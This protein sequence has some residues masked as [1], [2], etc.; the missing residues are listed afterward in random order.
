MTRL[1]HERTNL[2]KKALPQHTGDYPY[3]EESAVNI[4]SHTK[5]KNMKNKGKQ[6]KNL[7]SLPNG[8]IKKGNV[9]WFSDKKG[10]GFIETEGGKD[11]FVHHSS[12]RGSGFKTLTDGERVSFNI[13]ETG[14]GP[15]ANNVNKI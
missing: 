12:I 9:K 15:K 10:F 6:P 11:V 14:R 7:I 4:F 5:S 8:V 3:M 13:E 2:L 1:N